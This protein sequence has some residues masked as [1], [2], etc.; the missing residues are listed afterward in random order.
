MAS[1]FLILAI[2]NFE[3][4]FCTRYQ[5]RSTKYKHSASR[6]LVLIFERIILIS[7][8]TCIPGILGLSAD[9]QVHGTL[10]LFQILNAER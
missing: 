5:V 2:D 8:T 4:L 10:Y 3:D 1:Y 9:R 7:I 6:M